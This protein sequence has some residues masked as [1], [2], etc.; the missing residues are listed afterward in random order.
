M[1]TVPQ[2]LAALERRR[3][4]QETECSQVFA[5]AGDTGAGTLHERVVAAIVANGQRYGLGNTQN[6]RQEGAT[7]GN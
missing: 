6:P 2:R 1:A 5:H 7:D 4:V 3:Q